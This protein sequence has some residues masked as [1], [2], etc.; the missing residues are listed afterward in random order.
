MALITRYSFLLLCFT[1]LVHCRLFHRPLIL[2]DEFMA[3]LG[4]NTN[5]DHRPSKLM[6]DGTLSSYNDENVNQQLT[7]N[8]ENGKTTKLIIYSNLNLP[9]YLRSTKSIFPRKRN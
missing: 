6:D 1:L 7:N 9:R 3:M 2:D 4:S 8:Y 5:Q